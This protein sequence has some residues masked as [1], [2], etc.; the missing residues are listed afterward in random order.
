M[1]RKK[2][3]KKYEN[4]YEELGKIKVS[5][6]SIFCMRSECVHFLVRLDNKE[7]KED[8]IKD[9]KDIRDGL[10][11]EFH[12]RSLDYSMYVCKMARIDI[13]T[14]ILRDLEEMEG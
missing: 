10:F 5:D 7:T 4:K 2:L 1:N 13:I 14:E 9:Y 12:D 3:I 11:V 8:M 6:N